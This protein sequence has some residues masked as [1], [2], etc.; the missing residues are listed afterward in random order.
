MY[1]GSKA[2]TCKVPG[3][4]GTIGD[5]RSVSGLHEGSQSMIG[6]GGQG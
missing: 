4:M 1:V 2:F 3:G 6:D 5:T